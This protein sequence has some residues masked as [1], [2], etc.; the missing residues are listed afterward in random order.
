[1]KYIPLFAHWLLALLCT[2][3][4]RASGQGHLLSL[5]FSDVWTP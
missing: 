2:V 1:M 4:A 5:D 3:I